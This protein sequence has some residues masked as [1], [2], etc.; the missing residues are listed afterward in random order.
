MLVGPG[1]RL[2]IKLT[3][4]P[5][6][7]RARVVISKECTPGST[8]RNTTSQHYNTVGQHYNTISQHYN[9]ARQYYT[10]ISQHYNAISEHYD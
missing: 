6:S 4:T 10:T 5:L 8:N 9:T 7:S 1:A 2:T 3:N